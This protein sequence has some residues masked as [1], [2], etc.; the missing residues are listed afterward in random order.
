MLSLPRKCLYVL[1]P[2]ERKSLE[3]L[4]TLGCGG[5]DRTLVCFAGLGSL[6]LGQRV[7]GG[8]VS[9]SPLRVLQPAFSTIYQR[10]PK[11]TALQARGPQ[12]WHGTPVQATNRLGEGMLPLAGPPS[13][14]GCFRGKSCRC[15]HKTS[16]R[17][18]GR[19]AGLRAHLCVFSPDPGSP[20]PEP[21]LRAPVTTLLHVAGDV[22]HPVAGA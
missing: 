18:G 14:A 8:R 5:A 17:P 9:D 7:G 19:G 22:S 11:C 2:L 21:G 20:E 16:G 1:F 12:Q 13:R 15:P 6:G 10:L 3:N 4:D